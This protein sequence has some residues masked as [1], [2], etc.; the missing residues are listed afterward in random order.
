LSQRV[1]SQRVKLD[2]YQ[3][4]R[5]VVLCAALTSRNR[6]VLSPNSVA[7]Q[8]D[9]VKVVEDTLILSAAEMYAKEYSF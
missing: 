1:L 6:G 7:L 8:T 9:Y 4:L 2:Y 5:F 3:T